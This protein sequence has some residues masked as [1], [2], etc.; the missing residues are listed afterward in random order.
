AGQAA[1]RVLGQFHV[2]EQPGQ[3]DLAKRGLDPG[4]DG[5]ATRIHPDVG[6][7]LAAGDAEVERVQAQQPGFQQPVRVRGVDGQVRR[8][9]AA[10]AQAY[11]RVHRAQLVQLIGVR[12]QDLAPGGLF[13]GLGG[14]DRVELLAFGVRG[15]ADEAGEIVEVQAVGY[16]VG[17]E[18][19]AFAAGSDRGRPAQ[20]ALADLAGERVVVP[21]SAVTGE[22]AIDRVGR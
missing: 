5:V 2:R 18:E 6:A 16:Q 3:L 4:V 7:D 17:L 20:V 1:D 10:R 19:Q 21:G 13:R 9:D 14:E 22:A 12:R 11:V 15:R 8:V